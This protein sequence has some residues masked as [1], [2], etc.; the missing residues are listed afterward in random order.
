MMK[1][2]LLLSG[3]ILLLVLQSCSL[4]TETV[5]HKDAA[6][7]TEMNL[8]FAEM[9]RTMKAF[10]TDSTDQDMKLD[11][12]KKLPATWTTLYDL[13]KA[14]GGVTT[15]PDS[16][17]L[18]KKIF[19]KSNF[20]NGE[21][22]GIS[23]KLDHFTKLDYLYLDKAPSK[24]KIPL[25]SS[26]FGSWDGKSLTISSSDFSLEGFE[27]IMGEDKEHKNLSK[28]EKEHL[29]EQ[30]KLMLKMM[31]I[32]VTQKYKF[33]NKIKSITGKHDYLKQIDDRTIEVSYNSA[34]LADETQNLT[35]KDKEI[36]VVTE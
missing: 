20:D 28:E 21:I 32:E 23:I 16:V 19:A 27:K 14:E 8:N 12:L 2:F 22:A 34:Q 7:T 6:S 30:T 29:L 13:E 18:M 33:E 36:K 10:S 9:I 17:R 11:E 35:H 31:N 24:E 26:T 25:S 3:L 5:F 4:T 15:D 1:K